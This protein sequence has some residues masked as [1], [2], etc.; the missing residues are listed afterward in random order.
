VSPN[1]DDVLA[2]ALKT[3]HVQTP[4]GPDDYCVE[5]GELWPCNV[6]RLLDRLAASTTAREPVPAGTRLIL[7]AEELLGHLGTRNEYGERITA[8]WGEPSPEGWYE[9]VFRV[10]TDDRIGE[11]DEAWRAAEEALVS[12]DVYELRVG[13]WS[14]GS[15]YWADGWHVDMQGEHPNDM[16]GITTSGSTP[17]AALRSLAAKL[18]EEPAG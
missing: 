2:T 3:K 1:P 17:A 9:P 14:P 16:R 4:P 8:E 5:D 7:A 12:H 13:K 15:G 10:H 6:V 11:L 18:T